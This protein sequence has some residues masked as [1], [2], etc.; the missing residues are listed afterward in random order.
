MQDHVAGEGGG[1]AAIHVNDHELG[2][3]EIEQLQATYGVP[4]TPGRY[5]YDRRSGLY[6]VAGQAGMGFMLPGHEFGELDRSCSA[7][8]TGVLVNGRELP[9]LEWM[10]WSQILGAAIHPGGY[11]LDANGDAGIEGNP[12]P[13]VNFVQAAA[14]SAGMGSNNIW[15]SRLGAGNYDQGGKRGYVSVPGHG[16]IGYGF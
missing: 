5:W 9:N 8:N 15:S 7:G 14:A 12:M 16:P 10:L 1:G 11:W 2:S 3:D 4:P 13:L 6:G